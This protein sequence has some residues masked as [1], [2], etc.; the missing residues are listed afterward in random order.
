M[1]TSAGTPGESKRE[2][3]PLP[4][5][6]S[7]GSACFIFVSQATLPGPPVADERQRLVLGRYQRLNHQEALAIWRDVV[8]EIRRPQVGR[9]GVEQEPRGRR[10]ECGAIARNAHCHHFAIQR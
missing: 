7:P 6:V 3:R 4:T 2:F 8:F 1:T 9:R 10:L 5:T